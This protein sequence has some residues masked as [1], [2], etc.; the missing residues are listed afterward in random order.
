MLQSA[1]VSASQ[2]SHATRTLKE[3]LRQGKGKG[4]EE[5][6][7]N[8]WNFTTQCSLPIKGGWVVLLE[9]VCV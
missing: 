1:A 2:A 9:R 7:A 6:E 5:E 4:R 3:Y 8:Y